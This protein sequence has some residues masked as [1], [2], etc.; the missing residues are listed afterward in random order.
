[1]ASTKT[2]ARDYQRAISNSN[3][4]CGIALYNAGNLCLKNAQY[5]QVDFT[6]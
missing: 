3:E 1:M 5:A 4:Q 6:A 2:A